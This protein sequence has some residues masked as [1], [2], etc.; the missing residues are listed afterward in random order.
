MPCIN[1]MTLSKYSQSGLHNIACNICSSLGDYQIIS[2]TERFGTDAQTV[3]CTKCGLIYLNPRWSKE[4][5]EKFYEQD[6]RN[7]MGAKD[8]LNDR[9]LKQRIHGSKILGFCSEFIKDGSSVLEIGS[10]TGGI[11]SI[12]RDFKNCSVKGI[13]P[14]IEDSEYARDKFGL[15]IITGVFE[16]SDVTKNSF[17]LII[18]TQVLN[19]L[20]DPAKALNYMRSLL[21]PDGKLFIE[22]QN[23]PEY[24]KISANPMQVDHVYYFTPETL[25][26]LLRIVGFETVNIEVDTAQTAKSVS[27]YL[28]HRSASIHIRLLSSLSEPENSVKYPD[29]KPIYNQICNTINRTISDKEPTKLYYFKNM[30]KN[31]IFMV[32]GRNTGIKLIKNI[33]L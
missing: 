27:P 13:E 22:V 29:Y 18:V 1:I 32:L 10:A 14:S 20:L 3:I 31:L 12:F 30:V 15:D 33:K 11:L 23:F 19:H 28:W 17:D 21:K 25:E 5:Y 7:L 26:T 24:A 16:T 2:K 4:A 6:Y 9:F 8:D